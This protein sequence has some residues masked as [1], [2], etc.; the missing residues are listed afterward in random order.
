MDKCEDDEQNA[1]H[2]GEPDVGEEEAV[3]PPPDA[4]VE[5][6]TVMVL[7][8]DA[9]V[10]DAAVVGAWR[11]P[12]IATLAVFRRDFHGSSVASLLGFRVVG[13][14][15]AGRRKGLDHYPFGGRWAHGQR[16]SILVWV[17]GVWVEISRQDA[18]V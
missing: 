2:G 16:V 12:D 15:R 5:P 11:T 4:I 13:G 18:R 6:D 14:G 9:S 7:R 10:A 8:L 1:A 3:V 17:S